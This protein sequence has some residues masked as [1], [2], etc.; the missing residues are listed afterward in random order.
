MQTNYLKRI[1]WLLF[2][3]VAV[4]I[5]GCPQPTPPPAPIP[6]PMPSP[7]PTPIPERVLRVHGSGNIAATVL[8]DLAEAFLAMKGAE[9]ID[10]H[11]D[12]ESGKISTRAT[13]AER[14]PSVLIEIQPQNSKSAFGNLA[15][16]TCDLAL[17]SRRIEQEEV[18]K[19]F[20]SGDPSAPENEHVLA[21]DG[22]AV[23]VNPE[24]PIDSLNREQILRIFSGGIQDWSQLGGEAGRITP[25]IPDDGFGSFEA[26]TQL[27]PADTAFSP[28]AEILASESA[29]S[30]AVLADRN[31]IAFVRLAQVGSAK[32]LAVTIDGAL[33]MRP[34]TTNVRTEDYHLS[35]RLYLYRSPGV[36]NPL[37][38]DFVEFA[39]S[40]KGQQIVAQH[41]LVDLN[42][43]LLQGPKNGSSTDRTYRKI[44]RGAEQ[45]MLNL[46]FRDDRTQADNKALRDIERIAQ[47]LTHHEQYSERGIALLELWD[48]ARDNQRYNE[49]L[50]LEHAQSVAQEFRAHGIIA[51]V[52]TGF[53]KSI[54]ET[55]R[56]E[57]SN[58]RVEVWLIDP[59]RN[60]GMNRLAS[61][62]QV[63]PLNGSVT[64]ESIDFDKGDRSDWFRV[65]VREKGGT[66]TYLAQQYQG[67]DTTLGV[68]LY[69]SPKTYRTLDE[70]NPLTTFSLRGKDEASH[71]IEDA[72][73]GVY[74]AKVFAKGAGDTSSY[75][76]STQFVSAGGRTPSPAPIP[77][78]PSKRATPTPTPTPTPEP[79]PGTHKPVVRILSPEA[80]STTKEDFVLITGTIASDNAILQILMNG[81]ALT[82]NEEEETR[83]VREFSQRV[84]VSEI[85]EHLFVIAAWD[86]FGNIG[87]AQI[88][89]VRE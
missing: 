5:T 19:I 79:E 9:K 77:A 71:S 42:I 27:M 20:Y 70:N 89:I 69:Y 16:G 59:D 45:F 28:A 87:S 83:H 58:R 8:P 55:E 60:S 37:A 81:E 76:I 31:G 44:T 52:L 46:R 10:R 25:Y 56:D 51:S 54:S 32:I 57:T 74:Y 18:Q 7:S 50:P 12:A 49:A 6:E 1:C 15:D 40:Q 85:G 61:G 4:F 88:R 48:D 17:S 78:V 24:N 43:T 3:L 35:Y 14:V 41:E 72:E 26:F 86:E 62:A 80:N 34:D 64:G 13:V 11:I 75:K 38:R 22:I 33:S 73:P 65:V 30:N 2:F 66:L 21:L 36:E 82:L 84:S 67:Q 29:L 53:G 63:L 23:L 47:F 39:L 68:E